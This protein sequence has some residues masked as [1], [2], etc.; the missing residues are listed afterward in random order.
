MRSATGASRE[1]PTTRRSGSKAVKTSGMP[2]ATRSR[3]AETRPAMTKLFQRQA[4]ES[5]ASATSAEGFSQKR[6]MGNTS[7]LSIGNGRPSASIQPY[8][9]SGVPASMPSRITR[10]GRDRTPSRAADTALTNATSSST[11]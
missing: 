6:R 2:M 10:S 4:R 3:K 1:V 9:V 11:K 8:S 7:A 5:S